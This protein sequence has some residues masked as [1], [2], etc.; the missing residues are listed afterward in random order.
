MVSAHPNA[1]SLVLQLSSDITGLALFTGDLERAG[2]EA[3]VSSGIALRS[4][5]LKVGHHGSTTSTTD[6]FLAAVRP[7]Y[8]AISVGAHN[9]YR[10]PS[11]KII[12][13]LEDAG[14]VVSRTDLSGAQ[15]YRC[16][17]CTCAPSHSAADLLPV[18]TQSN[19]C[20]TMNR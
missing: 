20:G 18:F 6:A 13:K 14:A 4:A 12:A 5:L 19:S 1:D 16:S 15:R 11:S 7:S 10:H 17:A 8:A 9:L 2:E 3:L